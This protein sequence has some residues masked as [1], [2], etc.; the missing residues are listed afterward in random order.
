M[1]LIKILPA[2][3]FG[4]CAISNACFA[5][6]VSGN[7]TLNINGSD[8]FVHAYDHAQV[9]LGVNSDVA[10]LDM[11]DQSHVSIYGGKLSWLHLYEQSTA[12]L[13]MTNISW[14]LMADASKATVIGSDF[15]YTG[16]H[17]SGKWADGSPFSFWALNFNGATNQLGSIGGVMPSNL[18]LQTVPT[19]GTLY[20]LGAALLP[21]LAFRR[22]GV[23]N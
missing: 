15:S 2:L 3:F 19:P 23:K 20:L 6:I 16:G 18:I 12:T 21:L 10:F 17:L 22:Q 11:H 4:C 13:Y 5:T 14:L 1:R 9:N 8:A 7:N